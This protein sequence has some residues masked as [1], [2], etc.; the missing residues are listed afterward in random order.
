MTEHLGQLFSV[1]VFTMIS[2]GVIFLPII[3][4]E[5]MDRKKAEGKALALK[6][7]D[8]QDP[9]EKQKERRSKRRRKENEKVQELL[10]RRPLERKNLLS[11]LQQ[12]SPDNQSRIV[13]ALLP[14]SSP[15]EFL[16]WLDQTSVLNDLPGQYLQRY[17]KKHFRPEAPGLLRGHGDNKIV[18]DFVG[19]TDKSKK[20]KSQKGYLSLDHQVHHLSLDEPEES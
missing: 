9:K 10:S 18:A 2:L 4:F 20:E 1:S 6:R 12:F 3:I 19:R 11:H 14:G 5:V 7:Q 15:E 16:D 13:Q 17:L 8:G